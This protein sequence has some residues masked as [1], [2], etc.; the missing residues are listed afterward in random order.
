MPKT[1]S[2]PPRN[3]RSNS[4][5]SS[6]VPKIPCEICQT[7]ILQMESASHQQSTPHQFELSRLQTANPLI[8]NSNIHQIHCN[9]HVFNQLKSEVKGSLN[10]IGYKMLLAQGWSGDKGLGKSGQGKVQPIIPSSKNDKFGIGLS[11]KD[12]EQEKK[13]E[14]NEKRKGNDIAKVGQRLTP[15]KRKKQEDAEREWRKSMFRYLNE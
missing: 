6:S 5:S 7:L 10:E 11:K 15:A 1:R 9:H 14:E 2:N 13:R 4:S 8:D 12:K 3:T